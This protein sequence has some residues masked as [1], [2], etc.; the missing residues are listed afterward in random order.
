MAVKQVTVQHIRQVNYISS[1]NAV[2]IRRGTDQICLV[3]DTGEK[4]PK[5]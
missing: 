3:L 1:L 4:R 2:R 5:R